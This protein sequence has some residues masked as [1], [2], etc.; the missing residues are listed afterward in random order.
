[1]NLKIKHK[2]GIDF[3]FFLTLGGYMIHKS[4]KKIDTSKYT[5]LQ[6]EI[7]K[8]EYKHWDWKEWLLGIVVAVGAIGLLILILAIR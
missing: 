6:D 1:M 5:A 7:V 8:G 2:T 3:P 4:N